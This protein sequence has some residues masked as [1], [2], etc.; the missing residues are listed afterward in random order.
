MLLDTF[1]AKI[2]RNGRLRLPDLFSAHHSVELRFELAGVPVGIRSYISQGAINGHPGISLPQQVV[3]LLQPPCEQVVAAYACNSIAPRAQQVVGIDQVVVFKARVSIA[4]KSKFVSIPAPWTRG[5]SAI[6]WDQMKWVVH[7]RGTT[8][9]FNAPLHINVQG[10]GSFTIPAAQATALE[11]GVDVLVYA[12][13]IGFR[14]P[15]ANAWFRSDWF[16]AALALPDDVVTE[17]DGDHLVITS[18][19]AAPIRMRRRVPAGAWCYLLG[20]YQAE[21]NKAGLAFEIPQKT[22][23]LLRDACSQ[24]H[25]ASIA[26]ASRLMW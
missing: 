11:E 9:Q 21:G 23:E 18:P 12:R 5:F 15:M 7:Y 4:K 6:G 14:R 16:D 1:T 8:T 3:D 24:I 17:D 22:P 2:A 13:P 20:L 26:V 19:Y 10:V 25:L